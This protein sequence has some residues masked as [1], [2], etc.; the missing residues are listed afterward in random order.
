M[1]GFNMLFPHSRK[2][3]CGEKPLETREWNHDLNKNYLNVPIAVIETQSLKVP[4]DIR[5]LAKVKTQYIGIIWFKRSF[6]FP[7]DGLKWSREKILH[8]CPWDYKQR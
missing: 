7:P 8:K 6:K 4:K 1:N 3:V 5:D 2:V